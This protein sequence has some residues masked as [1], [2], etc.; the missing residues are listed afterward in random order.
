MRVPIKIGF[1]AATVSIV[2]ILFLI[3]NLYGQFSKIYEEE[4]ETNIK[5]DLKYH[6][7]EISHKID[8]IEKYFLAVSFIDTH[9]LNDS[10]EIE[11]FY[12]HYLKS[13]KNINSIMFIPFQ[14]RYNSVTVSRE[15]LDKLYQKDMEEV[16]KMRKHL[17]SGNIF[18]SSFY[19][20]SNNR[21]SCNTY[22]I[23]N[24]IDR[25]MKVGILNVK[26]SLDDI[27]DMMINQLGSYDEV[28]LFDINENKFIYKSKGIDNFKKDFTSLQK[29]IDSYK[30]YKIGF[31]DIHMRTLFL[32]L[33][34]LKDKKSYFKTIDKIIEKNLIL[35]VISILIAFILFSILILYILHPVK[36]LTD[37]IK[38]RSTK[39][40]LKESEIKDIS[41]DEIKNLMIY[42]KKF[43]ELIEK[44]DEKLEYYNTN[45]KKRIKYEVDKN[46]QQQ[47]FLMHQSKLA[48][49]G[50]MISMIAHQW[51][52][53]LSAI[54]SSAAD[55]KIKLLMDKYKTKDLEVR[56]D[57]IME[58][59]Q[60]LSETIDD[61][62]D[63]FKKDKIKEK[64]K[65][66]D[67]ID[68]TLKIVSGSLKT[69]NIKLIKEYENDSQINTYVSEIKQVV[70]NI[71]KN[72][73]DV[74][75]TQDK[76]VERFIKV[77]VYKDETDD[78]HIIQII[79][80][81]GGIPKKYIESIFDPYF[82][83]KKNKNGTGLGLYM[84]KS[85]VEDHCK[86][87]LEVSNTYTGAS[88]TIKIRSMAD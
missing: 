12:G 85:I 84:S 30:D 62:R 52:Q 67:I 29:D 23:V 70:L 88:F 5:H 24:D 21:L 17:P 49:M 73:E 35:I 19:Y 10:K 7:E 8:D 69:N 56:I 61:F 38:F 6:T 47:E 45:L 3:N 81:G 42:F 76:G 9:L 11:K 14:N 32:R 53:P 31:K 2:L 74:L 18:I 66:T 39:I 82:S 87:K 28:A 59:S 26:F 68:E 71:L 4:I 80:N 22:M 25:N 79:D 50:E 64:I 78:T 16:E 20:D 54:S 48:Q 1:I 55:I 63:F 77:K 44:K 34:Y 40:G 75:I 51:R 37:E 57:S 58:F 86:G 33:V 72:A 43:I 60:H 46:I 41:A 27:Q 13:N 15:S 83:T 36:R 65:T